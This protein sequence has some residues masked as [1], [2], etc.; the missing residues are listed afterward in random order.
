MDFENQRSLFHSNGN[1]FKMDL[2]LYLTEKKMNPLCK[3][4]GFPQSLGLYLTRRSS[5]PL[6]LSPSPLIIRMPLPP[7]LHLLIPLA[8]ITRILLGKDPVVLL[9]SQPLTFN[10][11]SFLTIAHSRIRNKEIPTITTYL[12]GH[13]KPSP[14]RDLRWLTLNQNNPI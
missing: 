7:L 3:F 2:G 1:A 11:T 12:L 4:D 8:P 10:R 9:F 13:L 6:C 14:P 5:L